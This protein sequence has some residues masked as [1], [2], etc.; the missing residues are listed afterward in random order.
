MNI[1]TTFNIKQSKQHIETIKRSIAFFG[2]EWV[3]SLIRGNVTECFEYLD[4]SIALDQ[5]PDPISQWEAFQWLAYASDHPGIWT[6]TGLQRLL[7]DTENHPY[8][9]NVMRMAKRYLE[10]GYTLNKELSKSMVTENGE[11]YHPSKYWKKKYESSYNCMYDDFIKKHRARQMK[12]VM[13]TIDKEKAASLRKEKSI[14]NSIFG[15][16]RKK[17][18]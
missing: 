18:S 17:R 12:K 3:H 8:M 7:N 14:I 4:R 9:Y 5:L 13:T 6:S 2:G 10:E 11:P 15:T 16:G 1:Y